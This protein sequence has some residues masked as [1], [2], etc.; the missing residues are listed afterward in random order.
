[1]KPT[2]SSLKRKLDREVSRIVRARGSCARCGKGAEQ[3]TLQCSHIIGRSNLAVRWSL[4]NCV[5]LCVGCHLYWWHREPLEASEW[6]RSYL[7]EI[8]LRELKDKAKTIKKWTMDE[9]VE[10]LKTLEGVR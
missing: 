2:K 1:M 7:G 10:L 3:V 6:V 4:D 9:L 8:K 5:A